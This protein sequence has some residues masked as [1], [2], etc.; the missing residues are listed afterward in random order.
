MRKFLLGAAALAAVMLLGVPARAQTLVVVQPFSGYTIGTQITDPATVSAILAGPNAGDVVAVGTPPTPTP[1]P[2]SASIASG[3][4]T[5][6]GWTSAIRPAA[7]AAG[8]MGFNSTTGLFDVYENGAWSSMLPTA[9]VGVAG[10]TL[11]LGTGAV[12][13]ASATLTGALTAGS[14]TLPT[15]TAA[16]SP[17]APCDILAQN[18]VT[19]VAAHSVTRLMVGSYTGPLFQLQRASDNTTANISALPN[20]LYN[21]ATVASFCAGTN[22]YISE[23]Y[24]QT[25]NSNHLPQT[26]VASMAPW[27]LYP[28]NGLPVVWT[29]GNAA[30]YRNRS[31]TSNIPTGASAAS[32]YYVRATDMFSSCCGDYGRMESPFGAP[33]TPGAMF[34]NAWDN[35]TGNT[36]SGALGVGVDLEASVPTASLSTVP[37]VIFEMAKYA[38]STNTVVV[39][40]WNA[41]NGANIPALRTI[42]SATPVVESGLSLG[43]GGDGSAASS[44]FFEGAVINGTVTDSANA[45]LAAN[46]SAFYNRSA[47]YNGPADVVLNAGCSGALCS[48]PN[49]GG[50]ATAA[51]DISPFIGGAWGLRL[52]RAS[53][54]GPVVTIRRASDNTTATIG[55]TANGDFDDATAQAFCAG[56]TCYATTLYNQAITRL[57]NNPNPVDY[58]MTQATASLQPQLVFG[59]LNNKAILRS[60]GTQY[61]CT[62]T[63]LTVVGPTWSMAT[64]ARRTGNTTAI[65]YAVSANGTQGDLGYAASANTAYFYPG[66]SGTT[67]SG[68]VTDSSW[69][70]VVGG[71]TSGNV[72]M[73]INNGTPITGTGT[74]WDDLNTNVCMFSA[75]Y[76]SSGSWV[77]QDVMTG[78]IAEAFVAGPMLTAA[79]IT[80]LYNNEHAYY[81][82]A[83]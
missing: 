55:T 57:N 59:V 48:A 47:S 22:C 27:M 3:Q 79:Q 1:Y 13:G 34:A 30:Y 72:S 36:I 5:L 26:A 51:R 35:W 75:S 78:D 43:E 46:I 23:I 14:A 53:Y 54:T 77:S 11:N 12:T 56:T 68:S 10:N 39:S 31:S 15:G 74:L 65:T 41:L 45:A 66:D 17:G 33:S 44:E 21:A 42:P 8:T 83:F 4:L 9:P 24:D 7:P 37:A 76:Y 82:G 49:T 32:G 73:S 69:A 19:C 52:L 38:P 2:T 60:A 29:S 70:A 20:G 63:S 18:G 61:L 58:N 28:T 40:S 62:S 64:V 25:G 81:G 71:N 67:A 16:I 6:G 50:G 80:A